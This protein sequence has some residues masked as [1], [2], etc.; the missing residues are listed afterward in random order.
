MGLVDN[1]ILYA[2]FTITIIPIITEAL[3]DLY[4]YIVLFYSTVN[5]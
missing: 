2:D 5:L 1:I 4:C 3:Q